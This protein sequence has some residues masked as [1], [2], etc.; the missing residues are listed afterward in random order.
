MFLVSD[1]DALVE[2]GSRMPNFF[3]NE[4]FELQIFR[5][6][7]APQI[8]QDCKYQFQRQKGH[9]HGH[10]FPY[11]FQKFFYPRVGRVTFEIHETREFTWST[12]DFVKEFLNPI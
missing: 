11:S 4:Q 1:G 9:F 10:I 3:D 7:Q 5:Y 12:C 6:D 2:H 8:H